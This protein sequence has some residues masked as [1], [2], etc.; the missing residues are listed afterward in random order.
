MGMSPALQ[1]INQ[2]RPIGQNEMTR[3]KVRTSKLSHLMLWG[4]QSTQTAIHSII[5][6][7][8]KKTKKTKLK[9]N[10]GTRGSQ[11]IIKI[12]RISP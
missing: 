9:P 2:S 12:I 5:G 10:G 8:F 3:L 6:E 7:V 1:V 11:K 4:T